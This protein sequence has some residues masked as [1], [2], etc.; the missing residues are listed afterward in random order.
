MFIALYQSLLACLEHPKQCT[1][2]RFESEHGFVSVL[3]LELETT[4][5]SK[6]CSRILGQYTRSILLCRQ[7]SFYNFQDKSWSDISVE[8]V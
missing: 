1:L 7:D 3:L 8:L 2:N 5:V 6:Y 4:Y